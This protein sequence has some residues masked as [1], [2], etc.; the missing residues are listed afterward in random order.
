MYPQTLPTVTCVFLIV[1]KQAVEAPV[2]A[3]IRSVLSGLSL[4]SPVA[5]AVLEGCGEF[6]R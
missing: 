1:R 5:G 2:T 6:R 4:W 3:W